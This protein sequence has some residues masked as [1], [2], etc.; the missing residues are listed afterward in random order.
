MDDSTRIKADLVPFT[1][2]YSAIV[3]S[4]IDSEETYDAVCR[5][6]SFP[7]PDDIVDSWQRKGVTSYLLLADRK[8]VAYGELWER[9]AERA[10]EVAHVMVDQYQRSRGYGTKLV[11]LLY[12]RASERPGVN[13]VLLNLYHDSQEALGC[14]LKAGFELVGTAT[15]IEGLKMMKMVK[16]A[17]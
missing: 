5:G 9:Q 2:E 8:P 1:S 10:V 7:P 15:H 17:E 3:R 12:E 16:K 11:R 6:I 14:F 4:W 13:R